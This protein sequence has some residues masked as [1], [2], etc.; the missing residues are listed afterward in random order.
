MNAAQPSAHYGVNMFSD[1]T[2]AEWRQ[3]RL[4]RVE[5][6]G[7]ALAH[8]CLT[9]GV[10]M[11]RQNADAIPTAFDWRTK[12]VV[13]PV[14]DQ[15]QCGSCWTFSTTGAIESAY[16][17][18][19][20]T[21]L[22]LSEQ[23]IVDCSHG[24]A[25]ESVYGV[26]CNQGCD[27]GWPWSAMNDIVSW[28]GLETETQYPYTAETGTCQQA[29]TL[30]A[31]ISN[32]TC[33]SGPKAADEQQMAAF[34]VAN[35]PLSIALDANDLF[36]YTSGVINDPNCDATSLDHAIL[37]VGYGVDSTQSPPLPYWIIKN[38]WGAT[39]GESGYFRLARG[40]GM[41]GVNEA[42]TFPQVA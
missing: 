27:G 2:R 39:W 3:E 26:V 6:S 24:C 38:S 42:V 4:S 10:T 34:L 22:G 29:G 37:I 31:K 5:V 17:I 13:S 14:K 18:K 15:G 32:Y 28:G 1:M 21:L 25:N 40:S 20:G 33:V 9:N 41:C 19:T 11:K 8:A 12:N 7:Q 30:S 16:A 36:S 35:G 23:Q